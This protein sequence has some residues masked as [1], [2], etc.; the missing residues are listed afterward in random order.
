MG[1]SQSLIKQFGLWLVFVL[2]PLQVFGATVG[3]IVEKQNEQSIFFHQSISKLAPQHNISLILASDL[4][5]ATSMDTLITIGSS[6]NPVLQASHLKQPVLAL[7]VNR[8]NSQKLR[9]AFP[10][11]PFSILSN[12]PDLAC[13]L[14]L[15]K[16]LTPNN[17]NVAV[18]KSEQYGADLKKTQAFAKK[19]GIRL[20]VETLND[21]LNWEREALNTL[22]DTDIVLGLDDHAIYN[23]TNIRSLLMRLYRA[24][25]PLIGPDKGYVRA[26][27]VAS[28]FS[29]VQET[30]LAVRDLIDKPQAWTAEIDNPYFDV[31]FNL[32]VARSLNIPISD[33]EELLAKVRELLK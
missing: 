11:R 1:S 28:C 17:H 2:C 13:Q 7:F 29:G 5:S 24:G 23:A 14:A 3:L 19:L 27:A 18:F 22:K 10:N 9:I 6:L 26:G 25:R 32:Q 20:T 15:I 12:T 8:A 33:S 4:T 31:G 16:V 21:P 30:L